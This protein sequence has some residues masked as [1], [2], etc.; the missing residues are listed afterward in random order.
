VLIGVEP[1]TVLEPPVEVT[2]FAEKMASSSNSTSHWRSSLD[3]TRSSFIES[4]PRSSLSTSVPLIS[5]WTLRQPGFHR[6]EALPKTRDLLLEMHAAGIRAELGDRPF[7]LTGLSSGGLVAHQLAQH[8]CDQGTPP[9]G[10]VILDSYSPSQ[11]ERLVR[12]LPG[13]GE[14]MR[15]RMDD[16]NMATPD[17][18]DWITATLHYEKFDWTPTDPPI[19]V[20]FVRA[21]S[22]LEGWPPDW[23]PVWPFDHAAAITRGNHFTVLEEHDPHTAALINEWMQTTFD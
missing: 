21:G 23:E 4:T 6:S 1:G 7:V 11:Y 10:V 16:P 5:A 9:A 14:E 13:L 17:A 22:P 8:L 12:L 18:N 20:L 19:P 2:V 15:H 3:T